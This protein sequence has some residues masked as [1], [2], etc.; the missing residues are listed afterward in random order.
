MVSDDELKRQINEVRDKLDS[1]FQNLDEIFKKI[2][3]RQNEINEKKARR[4][5]FNQ[6]VKNLISE[7]KEKQKERDHLRESTR[8]K[9]EII[10]NLKFN[11]KEYA[12]QINDLKNIRDG[13]HREAKGSIQGLQDNLAASLTTLLNMDLS[14][15][16]ENTLF[17]MI[18]STK[19][20]YEAKVEAD[21]I[22]QQI[23]EVYQ[24]IKDTEN[25]IKNEEFE[26]SMV[27]KESQDRHNDSI[28]KFKEKDQMREKSNELHQQ[29]LDGYKT[30][31]DLKSQAE[32]GKKAVAELKSELNELYKKLRSG[33]K[34]RREIAKKEKLEDAKQKLK[35]EKKMD[36]DELRLLLESGEFKK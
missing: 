3:N 30:I 32:L 26:I 14:L 15:K 33:E 7:A 24:A 11:I 9:R 18:F 29:V 19:E 35:K 21:D 34:K 8:P 17:N 23:Q 10:K 2:K 22:H 12:K 28:A 5:D 6:L 13:K 1:E 36:L 31:K 16:D 4:D 20:R 25:Q 27:L